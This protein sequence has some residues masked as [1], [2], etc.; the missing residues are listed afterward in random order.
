MSSII[1][2]VKRIM[3]EHKSQATIVFGFSNEDEEKTIRANFTVVDDGLDGEGKFL[4][5]KNYKKEHDVEE[6]LYTYHAGNEGLH[7]DALN[8][9]DLKRSVTVKKWAIE[10]YKDMDG[11]EYWMITD[12]FEKYHYKKSEYTESQAWTAWANKV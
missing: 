6:Q 7:E 3:I 9:A 2:E 8:G 11:S 5:I 1:E 4:I 10:S 12:G